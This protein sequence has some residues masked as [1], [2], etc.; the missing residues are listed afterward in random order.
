M[1]YSHMRYPDFDYRDVFA[2][3]NDVALAGTLSLR[4]INEIRREEKESSRKLWM[5]R[6][7]ADHKPPEVLADPERQRE[8]V[9]G[10][11]RRIAELIGD[12]IAL[13]NENCEE[14]WP[15]TRSR[16]YGVWCRRVKRVG[17]DTRRYNAKGKLI[18]S[19]HGQSYQDDGWTHKWLALEREDVRI[20][21]ELR[22][23]IDR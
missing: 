4:R 10:Y 21:A 22:A 18:G 2:G 3:C 7:S 11:N 8:Y 15:S 16:H 13:H 9:A 19:H 20:K 12:A 14:L 17:T 1:H 5:A 6:V 23:M